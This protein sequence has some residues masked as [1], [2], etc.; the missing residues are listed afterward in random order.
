MELENSCWTTPTAILDAPST[1]SSFALAQSYP[2]PFNSET[3]IEFVVPADERVR[4]RIYNL[5]GQVV[6]DLVDEALVAGTH[7]TRWDAHNDAGQPV[8]SGVYLY[9]LQA[10]ELETSHKL[11]LVR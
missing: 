1:P 8:A 7:Q 10:G 6:T 5:S 3:V 11:V 4:L 9:R 2:N